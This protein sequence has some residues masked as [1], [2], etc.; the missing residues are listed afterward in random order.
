[1]KLLHFPTDDALHGH[2]PLRTLHRPRGCHRVVLRRLRP[3]R[4]PRLHV[5]LRN[6]RHESRVDQ[7]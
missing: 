4:R 1:M 3:L 2:R 6:R 5:L 7:R